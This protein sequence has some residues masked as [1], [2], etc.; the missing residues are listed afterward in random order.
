[1]VAKRL[2]HCPQLFFLP[3]FFDAVHALK[4]IL[5]K[6]SPFPRDNIVT[7]WPLD[8]HAE[9]S[10]GGVALIGFLFLEVPSCSP[11]GCRR[12]VCSEDYVPADTARVLRWQ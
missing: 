12:G 4:F 3:R 2:T 9:A 1:M 10:G 7:T 11:S 8:L 5:T 6:R